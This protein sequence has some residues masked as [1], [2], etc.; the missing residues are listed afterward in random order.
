MITVQLEMNEKISILLT[1]GSGFIGKNLLEYLSKKYTVLS[2][3]HTELDLAEEDKVDEYFKKNKID[4]IIHAASLGVKR[5]IQVEDALKK[6]LK[7][8]FNIVKNKDKVKKIIFF[9]SGAEY[10]KSRD[11]VNVKESEF[12]KVI[13]QDDYGFYKYVCSRY[14]ENSDKIINLRIFGAFGPYEDY[15]SRFISNIMCRQIFNLPIEMNQNRVMDY[16]DI[17]DF[18][19]IIGYFIENDAK[20]KFYNVGGER[21]NLLTLAEKIKNISKDNFEIIVKKQG[22]DKEYTCDN[23]KLLE[24]L[25]NFKFTDIDTSLKELYEWYQINKSNLDRNKMLN[26]ILEEKAKKIRR[27]CLNQVYSAKSSHIGSMLSCADILAYLFYE[28]MEERDKF[29]LSKGHASLALYSLLCDKQIISNDELKSY[30]QNGSCLIGHLN[31]KVSGVEV[32]TGSLG[33]GLPISTGMALAK[34]IDGKEGKVFCLLGDGECQEGSIWE[35]L[36]FISAHHLDNLIILIDANKLQ[37]YNLCENIFEE[38]KLIE[39]LKSTGI[40]FYEINGHNF[41]DMTKTFTEIKNKKNN[42]SSIIFCHT[43][44]GKGISF[45]ENKLEW[46]YKSPSEEQL[47]EAISELK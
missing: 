37:G 12:G 42:Q 15:T 5:N 35:A 10:N 19:K 21:C 4:I 18:C 27:D 16:I 22:V 23:N 34:K 46:H 9:G 31:N 7:I 6:N 45:M 36:I 17:K 41:N 20:E 25:K 33:H 26:S 13:P 47:K 30:C 28:E 3:S 2:P 8:F 38:K 40:N 44:K 29:V 39:M 24:E 14:I 1:G 11:L 43:I 32:S